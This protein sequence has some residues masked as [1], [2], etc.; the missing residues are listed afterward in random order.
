V[1]SR[2]LHPFDIPVEWRSDGRAEGI[3]SVES[4][5]LRFDVLTTLE[6]LSRALRTAEEIERE[7]GRF[8]WARA[9]ATMGVRG[10]VLEGGGKSYIARF[11]L[12][13][14]RLL[15][16]AAE[17]DFAGSL[18][19]ETDPATFLLETLHGPDP[20][21]VHTFLEPVEPAGVVYAVR[22]DGVALALGETGSVR[23][24]DAL[25]N[26]PLVLGRPHAPSIPGRVFCHLCDQ[27]HPDRKNCP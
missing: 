17:E 13:A 14:M 9:G 8:G 19:H 6:I 21:T 2:S 24:L 1:V 23:V 27:P 20:M 3:F 7:L 18:G 25:P 15:P 10:E 16:D 12:D 26:V 5:A 11:V 22:R 4:L